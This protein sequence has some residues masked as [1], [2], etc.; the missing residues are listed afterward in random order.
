[1]DLVLEYLN[2]KTAECVFD[3]KF[4]HYMTIVLGD[5]ATGKSLVWNAL[6]EERAFIENNQ[7]FSEH[8]MTDYSGYSWSTSDLSYE[9]KEIQNS[10][11]Q[12]C[13]L[14][15]YLSTEDDKQNVLNA[16]SRLIVIDNAEIVLAGGSQLQEFINKD[17]SN[18]YLIF[19]RVGCNLNTTIAMHAV[20]KQ[21][22]DVIRLIHIDN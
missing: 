18:Q 3:F 15:N 19:T 14:L 22:S 12:R 11:I 21:E 2:L 7:G 6:R 4:K 9:N 10:V 5:S 17:I 8:F 13:I 1:M 16:E 20:L